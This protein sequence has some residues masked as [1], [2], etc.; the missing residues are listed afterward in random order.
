MSFKLDAK[1]AGIGLV[2][3][4]AIVLCLGAGV[5]LDPQVKR[6]AIAANEGH[7][8]ILDT[9]TGQVWEKFTPPSNASGA[10]GPTE[11]AAPKLEGSR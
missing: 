8:F 4:A 10:V 7:A 2:L 1:S 9:A 3:G 11:F 5:K 6:Y